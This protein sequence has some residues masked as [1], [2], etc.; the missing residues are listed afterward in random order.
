MDMDTYVLL[1]TIGGTLCILGFT[2]FLTWLTYKLEKSIQS[3]EPERLE[4]LRM[5][6]GILLIVV[7]LFFLTWFLEH[8]Y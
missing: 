8:P 5:P 6:L 1:V 4:S 7:L 2:G 3:W